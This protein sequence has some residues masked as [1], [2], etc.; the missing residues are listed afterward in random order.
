MNTTT[1][2]A[3]VPWILT[4]QQPNPLHIRTSRASCRSLQG[5]NQGAIPT[6]LCLTNNLPLT[7]YLKTFHK[8]IKETPL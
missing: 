2:S 8:I 5:K 4:P 1:S 7:T 6:P 3:T